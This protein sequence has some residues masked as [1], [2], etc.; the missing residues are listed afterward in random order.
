MQSLWSVKRDLERRFK[1][2]QKVKFKHNPKL[3][4]LDMYCAATGLWPAH[5]GARGTITGYCDPNEYGDAKWYY[6]LFDLPGE[7]FAT[8]D[9]VHDSELEV[10]DEDCLAEIHAV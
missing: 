4:G 9:V 6:V 3:E 1:V 10:L 8:P 2:G 7:R 5:D